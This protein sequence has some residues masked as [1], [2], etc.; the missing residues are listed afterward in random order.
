M[1]IKCVCACVRFDVGGLF[2]PPCV[3][4]ALISKTAV[5]A[6]IPSGESAGAVFH[7]VVIWSHKGVSNIRKEPPSTP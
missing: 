3:C 4:G 1:G 5:E 7:K 2:S 6:K